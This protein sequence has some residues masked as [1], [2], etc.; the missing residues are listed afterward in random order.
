MGKKSASKEKAEP[1]ADMASAQK[2][3]EDDE[4]PGGSG[5]PAIKVRANFSS[6]AGWFPALGVERGQ[7]AAAVTFPDSLTSWRAIAVAV[8]P[9]PHLG[10][11]RA[12]V[13]TEKPLM[14]RLQAPRFFTERDEVTISAIVTSRLLKSAKVDVV[15]NAPGLKPLDGPARTVE[16]APGGEAR[17]DVRYSAVEAGDRKVRVTARG[18]GTG[19]AMEWTLPLVVHGSAQRRAF[20]GR[21]GDAITLEMPLPERR[22]PAGTRFE[23]DLSPTLLSVMLDGLPYLAQY[24][25]G[26]VEQ[27]LSRFVPAAIAARTVKNLGVPATRVPADLDDM[28]GAGLKRLYAFQHGDGGWGWWQNDATNRWMSAYVVYG[29]SLGKE[30]GLAVDDSVVSRGRE[31]LKS[32]LGEALSAPEEHAFMTFALARTGGA[33]KAALDK[34]F[35]RR[36]KLSNRGRALVALALLSQNDKRAR[37]AVENLDDVVTAAK[38][39]ADAS[40]GDANDIWQTSEAIEATSWTLMAMVKHD[41]HSPLVK[42]LVDFLVLRRNGGKWRTTR[43]T[44]FAIYALSELAAKEAANNAQGSFAVLVNGKVAARVAYSK[45]GAD[46]PGPIVLTDSDFKPGTNKIEIRKDG[47]AGTGYYAALFD[48]FNQDEN[49]KAVGGDVAITRQ[50]T[51]LGKPSAERATAPFEYGMAL[52]SGERVRVDIE[53]KANKAV[54]FVMLEDLKAAGLEA[55]LQ[56]SGQEVCNFAC[57]HAELRTD[58]VAMFLTQLP[59]GTTKLSY[60]LRAEVPGRYHALPARFEAMYAPEIRATSDEMRVEVRDAKVAGE[61]VAGH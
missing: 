59:V 52:D 58:R 23:L 46:L 16:V 15:F 56:K 9:G 4:A 26:C 25:Y 21:L 28:V 33:P 55:V 42:P 13:R 36:T 43:D 47:G 35:E 54:E 20:S 49:L 61:G 41:P 44:A 7:A 27:T 48:V 3:G 5:A 38:E 14:V 1:A 31:Y 39:R 19:D 18:G 6:S 8:T 45:G 10:I 50:Y 17:V 22:N 34:D 11:G 40:V 53:I 12:T 29:L 37:I 60:E 30:A 57:A 2:A 32:H 24:P 51:V